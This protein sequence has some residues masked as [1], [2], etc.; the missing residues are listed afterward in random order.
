MIQEAFK[1]IVDRIT[2]LDWQ[3]ACT[4]DLGQPTIPVEPE[5]PGYPE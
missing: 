3:A 1:S 5:I 2:P 4:K